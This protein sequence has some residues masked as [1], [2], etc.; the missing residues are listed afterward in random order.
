MKV[1]FILTKM[2]RMWH[3]MSG[4][5][6]FDGKGALCPAQFSQGLVRTDFNSGVLETGEKRE[7]VCVCVGGKEG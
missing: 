4:G 5:G 2:N 7:C 1:Y 3:R 6:V